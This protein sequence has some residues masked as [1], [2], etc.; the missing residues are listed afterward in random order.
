M[1]EV[2]VIIPCYNQGEYIDEAV[3]S[4][5]AQTFQDFEI[6]IVNDGSTDDFTNEKL[7]NYN[8]PK[9][10][11]IHTENQ[12]LAAARNNG[13]RAS[14]GEYILPL[15]ADDKIKPTFIKT[16]LNKI[17]NQQH[18]KAIGTCVEFF[19]ETSGFICPEGGGILNFLHY[20]NT[21][22]TTLFRKSDWISING[23]DERMKD[24]YEDWDFWIRLLKENGE[25][26]IIQDHLFLYRKRK[27]SMLS[28]SEKKHLTVYSTIINNN[29]SIFQTH[30][31]F[32][33]LQKE[34]IICNLKD[35]IFNLN[36]C[37]DQLN[38]KIINIYN[39]KSYKLGDLILH[40]ISFLKKLFKTS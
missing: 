40:P 12:G 39:S 20:N 2:S 30:I 6:I 31:N 15:D 24:G 21:V 32:V 22:A 17:I 27:N 3:D 18:I 9:T 8:K 11:V 36:N 33:V 38:N 19:G 34:R 25:I 28:D 5:L 7:K 23:Y 35:E 4:V 26:L 37:V 16:V 1:A 14:S 10:R 29:I 13:I